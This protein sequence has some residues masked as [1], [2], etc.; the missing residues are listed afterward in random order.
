[1]GAATAR[2]REKARKDSEDLWR[3]PLRVEPVLEVRSP[4]EREDDRAA[5]NALDRFDPRAT[6][7]SRTAYRR[8]LAEQ[9]G[10]WRREV[11]DR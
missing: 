7:D 4:E 1:M 11:T 8:M 10:A 3:T 6:Y 2:V 5:A 9:E